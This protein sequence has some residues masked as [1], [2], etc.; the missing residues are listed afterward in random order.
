M[1]ELALTPDGSLVSS[2]VRVHLMGTSPTDRPLCS[3]LTAPRSA[4]QSRLPLLVNLAMEQMLRD[5]HACSP[6]RKSL[7]PAY[8][9]YDEAL[10]QVPYSD[11]HDAAILATLQSYFT[12]APPTAIFFYSDEDNGDLAYTTSIRD[13]STKAFGFAIVFTSLLD[14]FYQPYLRILDKEPSNAEAI[15]SVQALDVGTVEIVK[16]QVRHFLL[17]NVLSQFL[18]VFPLLIAFRYMVRRPRRRSSC[19]ELTTPWLKTMPA[20]VANMGRNLTWASPLSYSDIS[21]SFSLTANAWL[22]GLDLGSMCGRIL[23]AVRTESGWRILLQE[24][25]KLYLA[26]LR[27]KTFTGLPNSLFLQPHRLRSAS[28]L[29]KAQS[30]LGWKGM[31]ESDS[32][33]KGQASAVAQAVNLA[34]STSPSNNGVS[35]AGPVPPTLAH[36]AGQEPESDLDLPELSPEQKE[37]V[38]AARLVNEMLATGLSRCVVRRTDEI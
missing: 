22:K 25:I 2:V 7:W 8:C 33:K 12:I 21:V 35:P 31:R 19:A 16:H 15:S 34:H 26:L 4:A 5:D 17:F 29:E 20:R 32:F 10:L 28:V 14:N 1:S 38:E 18:Q 13:P 9:G 37:M 36:K 30:P 3:L 27:R 11:G 6:I 23:L 24:T